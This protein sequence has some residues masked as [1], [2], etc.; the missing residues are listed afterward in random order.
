[1]RRFYRFRYCLDLRNRLLVKFAKVSFIWRGGIL[2]ALWGLRLLNSR[3]RHFIEITELVIFFRLFA[4]WIFLETTYPIIV[5]SCG[6]VLVGIF[7]VRK[8]S[9]SSI[10]VMGSS[11]WLNDGLRWLTWEFS[12]IIDIWTSIFCQVLFILSPVAEILG[13]L[14]RL[15]IGLL[16]RL[17][18]G[19]FEN[20]NFIEIDD[21]NLCCFLRALFQILKLR[22][23]CCRIE[24]SKVVI[25]GIWGSFFTKAGPVFSWVL[26]FDI[27]RFINP[28]ISFVVK[29]LILF[30][31]WFSLS[32]VA[33]G[34]LNEFFNFFLFSFFFGKSH[35]RNW[36]NWTWFVW[37]FG[38]FLFLLVRQNLYIRLFGPITPCFFELSHIFNLVSGLLFF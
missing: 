1:M 25:L 8:F 35:V 14:L 15:F 36:L 7:F 9:E 30:L 28:V 26:Y 6:R 29:F 24:L 10:V 3:R 19:N 27:L 17:F 18:L 38:R 33:R 2:L 34:S 37:K 5:L 11:N 31:T 23:R 16:L 21:C 22:L 13:L 4:L 12:E 20:F 32:K